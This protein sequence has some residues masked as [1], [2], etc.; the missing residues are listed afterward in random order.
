MMEAVNIGGDKGTLRFR[1]SWVI[2]IFAAV[3]GVFFAVS[4]PGVMEIGYAGSTQPVPMN[5]GSWLLFGL[6]EMVT[7][8]FAG[9]FLYNAGPE[10]LDLN[11]NRRTYCYVF[12]W[13][14]APHVWQ[15]QWDE[16]AGIYLWKMEA[17]FVQCYGVGVAWKNPQIQSRIYTVLATFRGLGRLDRAN[18]M[19]E[20]I[21]TVLGLPV[22]EQS[23]T[24]RSTGS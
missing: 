8:A 17:G 18:Q 6:M 10:R 7:L 4:L 15:G 5:T 9:L 1:K 14:F 23:I 11:L 3:G 2:R 24:K 16:M 19:A 12:G 13:P 22:V 21:I 20:E